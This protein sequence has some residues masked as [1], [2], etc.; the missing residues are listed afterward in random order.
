MKPNIGIK[1]S[2]IE[3]LLEI[4]W[5]GFLIP[6]CDIKRLIILIGM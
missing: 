1:E 6:A 3:N 4:D 5:L 2:V